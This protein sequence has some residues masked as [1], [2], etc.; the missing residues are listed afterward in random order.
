[1]W[2][3]GLITNISETIGECEAISVQKKLLARH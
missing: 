1:M 2:S 3:G